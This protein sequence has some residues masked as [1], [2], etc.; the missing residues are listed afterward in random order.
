M[1]DN[2]DTRWWSDRSRPP[3]L[4]GFRHEFIVQDI[5][6][7]KISDAYLPVDIL[8]DFVRDIIF[9]HPN[10]G[11][12]LSELSNIILFSAMEGSD[13]YVRD[14]E[15][16]WSDVLNQQQME[17]LTSQMRLIL[18]YMLLS[19]DKENE[20]IMYIEFFDTIIRGLNIGELMIEKYQSKHGITLVPKEIIDT[21]ARYWAKVLYFTED[22]VVK[23]RLIDEYI[24][25]VGIDRNKI[26]W[27]ELYRISETDPESDNQS[28]SE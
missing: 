5:D 17:K 14:G 6:Q 11:T 23:R 7:E 2:I 12:L 10:A 24:E 25:S 28:E 9:Q 20:N 19:S 13:R 18:G 1:S 26:S 27:G 3:P 8:K 4:A 16:K 21:S 15:L 22:G